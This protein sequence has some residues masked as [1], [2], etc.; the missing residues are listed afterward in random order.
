MGQIAGRQQGGATSD[1]KEPLRPSAGG[2]DGLVSVQPASAH[3]RPARPSD[4]D[5]AG[6]LC[7]LRHN[8]QLSTTKLVRLS[9]REALAEMVVSAGSPAP[10]PLEPGH[11]TPE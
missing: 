9:S 2:G 7:L 10:A 8:R 6:P 1:G 4:R 3:P 11:R 5:D